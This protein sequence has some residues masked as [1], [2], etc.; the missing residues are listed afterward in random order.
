[1]SGLLKR[2]SRSRGNSASY[3]EDDYARSPS[4]PTAPGQRPP[5]S[6]H[7]PAQFRDENAV[8]A[9][10]SGAPHPADQAHSAPPSAG[11]DKSMYPSSASAGSTGG[12][13]AARTQPLSNGA[14][15]TSRGQSSAGD[16]GYGDGPG[17]PGVH[18]DAGY[19][20]P[21]S[22][23]HA[24]AGSMGAPDLLTRAFNEAVRPYTEKIEMLE[25][26]LADMQDYIRSQ[27]QQRMEIFAWIDK[28]GL[29][30]DVPAHIA[31]QMDASSSPQAATL[32]NGQ[33][34]RKITIVNFDLHRLQDDL[35]DSISSAHFA[36][37]MAKFIPDIKRLASLRGGGAKFAYE[38]VIKLVGNLNSHGGLEAV[39][40]SG[41]AA[42]SEIEE[43][44]RARIMFYQRMDDE[45]VA[46]VKVRCQAARSGEGEG[47]GGMEGDGWGKLGLQGEVK[48][49]ERNAAYLKN[50]GVSEYFPQAL[51]VMR[52]EGGMSGGVGGGYNTPPRFAPS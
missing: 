6:Y 21:G 1:M 49:L 39:E 23:T 45:L 33:L 35:N 48:R 38:L 13:A 14:L 10:L 36:S 4:S 30:P 27:E 22:A 8:H 17:T 40:E 28:R 43:D 24:S 9:N 51:E 31:S 52:R 42:Q 26:E 19:A 34:D 46:I 32:L 16:S 3:V 44:R 15:R 7:S 50:L 20:N 37:A 11:P 2:F 41:A 47:A 5:S 18:K 29:R 12:Y 25:G